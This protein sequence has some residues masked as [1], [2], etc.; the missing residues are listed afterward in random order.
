MIPTPPRER[1]LPLRRSAAILA[2]AG[3][4]GAAGGTAGK[5]D[6]PSGMRMTFGLEQRLEAVRNED[7]AVAGARGTD[8]LAVTRLSLG[9]VS[10]TPREGFELGLSSNLRFGD[11]ANRRV[12][13]F[14]SPAFRLSYRR[15]GGDSDFVANARLRRTPVDFLRALDQFLDEDG[16]LDLPEDFDDLAG[17]GHRS[18]YAIDGQLTLGRAAAPLGVTF[19]LGLLGVRYG[20]GAALN[21]FRRQSAGASLRMRMSPLATAT[22]GYSHSRRSDDDAVDSRRTTDTLRAG[23]GYDVSPRTTISGSLG[24]SRIDTTGTGVPRLREEGL[25]GSFDIGVQTPRGET[26]L[27]LEAQRSEG[28]RRLSAAL[29]QGLEL[30]GGDLSGSFGVARLP[31]NRTG[32]IGTLSWQRSLADG[33]LFVSGSRGAVGD[34]DVRLR[35]NVSAAFSR[36]LTLRSSMNLRADYTRSSASPLSNRLEAASLQASY[37]HQLTPD[38]S[39]NS[40]LTYRLRREQGVGRATSPGVFIGLGRQF[41]VPL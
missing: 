11:S 6:G 22:L 26:G 39:L 5:A 15:Q 23:I 14:D 30:P 9:L 19:D 33:T 36:Q 31:G 37:S 16:E 35:S 32:T 1:R 20:G 13:E 41:E 28:G 25:V 8:T 24:Y 4:V 29:R 38:W 10:D 40:G 2:L 7:L 12:R 34:D 21:D 3:L 18:E 27:R 17:R